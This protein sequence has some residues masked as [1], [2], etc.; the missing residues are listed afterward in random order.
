MVVGQWS[1]SRTAIVSDAGAI[2]GSLDA[3]VVPR[4]RGES[5]RQRPQAIAEGIAMQT[6]QQ[7]WLLQ[8]YMCWFIC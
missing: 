7:P 3:D 4:R 1:G 2:V 8:S 6:C 5:R